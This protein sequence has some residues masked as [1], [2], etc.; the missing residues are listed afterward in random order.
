MSAA[1]EDRR[2]AGQR[3]AIA[4]ENYA[5]NPDALVLGLPRG[6]VPV[7]AEVARSLNLPLN[8]LIVRKISTANHPELAIGAVAESGVRVLETGIINDLGISDDEVELA[9]ISAEEQLSEKV[10]HFRAILPFPDLLNRAAIVVDDGI[11]TGAT[12]RAAIEAI[13]RR[14]PHR[15]VVA[16]PIG[17]KSTCNE[18]RSDADEVIC[19][20]IPENFMA[21]SQGYADFSPTSDREVDALI[22]AER[23]RNST[24]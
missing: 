5:N 12:I 15:I 2:D 10:V 14:Q 9:T 16:A 4:L 11:A 17:S 1:F 22:V 18:L 19:W 6:G 24:A 13:R 20:S 21:V 23:D 7:A 8:M 3:L